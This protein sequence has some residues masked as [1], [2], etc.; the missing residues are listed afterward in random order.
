M[1]SSFGRS[2]WLIYALPLILI[3]IMSTAVGAQGLFGIGFPGA[4]Y[5]DGFRRGAVGSGTP[6]CGPGPTV[7]VGECGLCE[8]DQLRLGHPGRGSCRPHFV[9]KQLCQ[10]RYMAGSRPADRPWTAIRRVR[11]RMDP[12]SHR[13]S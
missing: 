13:H 5:L 2:R 10:S 9:S 3:T 6:G 12:A 1:E 4:S 7:Y 11:V 8:R